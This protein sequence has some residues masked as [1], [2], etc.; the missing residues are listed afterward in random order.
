MNAAYA[1]QREFVR[2]IGAER[3]KWIKIVS[4]H[5]GNYPNV[6]RGLIV[7][8]EEYRKARIESFRLY[9]RIKKAR[10]FLKL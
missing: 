8:S 4:E 3:R 2:I 7:I 1:E 6:E 9:L 5:K 10:I